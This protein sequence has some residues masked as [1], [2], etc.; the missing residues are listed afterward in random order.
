MSERPDLR[1]LI[2]S[3]RD[4]LQDEVVPAASDAR[5]RFRALVAANVLAV[6]LRDLERGEAVL[7]EEWRGLRGLGFV[8]GASSEPPASRGDLEAAVD[9]ANRRLAGA[10]R[11]GRLR[12]APGSA[13]WRHV[14]ETLVGKL[15]I[16]NPAF[17]ERTGY[18]GA[19]GD[20]AER[21]A[22]AK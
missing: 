7:R 20:G 18:G 21:S 3:A 2:A 1:E 10:L 15:R 12:A 9:G 8:E 13:L 19:P 17:L 11:A 6:A 4:F 22:G 5:L 16:A 14:R